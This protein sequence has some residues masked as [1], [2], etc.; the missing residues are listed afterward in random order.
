M[1]KILVL[2]ALLVPFDVLAQTP[3]E[4]ATEP[5]VAEE[6]APAPRALTSLRL[7]FDDGERSRDSHTR[8][9][10]FSLSGLSLESRLVRGGRRSPRQ[11][12]E[13]HCEVEFSQEQFAA[14]ENL[15]TDLEL[16]RAVSDINSTTETGDYQIA[17]I[18]LQGPEGETRSEV[19]GMTN[20]WGRDGGGNVSEVDYLAALSRMAHHLGSLATCDP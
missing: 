18:V 19:R 13:E 17:R 6:E 5:S 1:T 15:A 20:I 3:A 10:D 9:H 14:I 2:F 16:W 12:A 11:A 4:E 7:S 8:E